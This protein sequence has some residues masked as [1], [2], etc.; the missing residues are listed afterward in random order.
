MITKTVTQE[1]LEYFYY[2]QYQHNYYPCY[3]LVKD[4]DMQGNE[5]NCIY[6][7]N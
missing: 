5:Y 2:H 7:V 4:M 3:D 6:I 1:L